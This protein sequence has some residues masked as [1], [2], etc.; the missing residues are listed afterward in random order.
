M[1]AGGSGARSLEET[2]TWAVALVCFVMLSIS[3]IIEHILHLI[4]KWLK[5]KHK[6]DLYE[7]LEKIKSELMLLGFISLLITVAYDSI[8]RICVSE[9]IAATWHPCKNRQ[10]P[11]S[12]PVQGN[13][14][15]GTVNHR[16]V[17]AAAGS[18]KCAPQGKV[19]LVSTDGIHQLHVFIFVWAVFHVLFCLLTLALGRLKMRR[20]KRWEEETKTPEYQS[21]HDPERFRF[22]RE[23]S[24]G[25]RH[26]SFW[27]QNPLLMWI[28]CFFR[29]F[30]RS[31][32]K[33]DYLALRH[34]FIMAHLAPQ[35]HERFD[36]RNY[37]VRSL[38]QDFK[39]VVG[40]SPPFWFFAVFF[41][42]SGTHGWYSYLWFPFIPLIIILVVGTKLQVIITKMAQG[43]QQRGEVV[44]GEPVVEPGDDLFWFKRPRFILY[45]INFALFQNAFQLAFFAWTVFQF[46]LRSCFNEKTQDV[47]IRITMGVFVQFLCSYV[48]LPL[49]ALVTQMGSTMRP[50]IFDE[51]VA[52][53]IRS[54]HQNAKK[55]V[56]QNKG[57]ASVTPLLG[58]PGSSPINLKHHHRNGGDPTSS[59]QNGSE[60]GYSPDRHDLEMAY[61]GH[62]KGTSS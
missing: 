8:S 37:I 56:R 58:T 61:L 7:S 50:T 38:E 12:H 44:K 36:F 27:T 6:N 21:S 40:I 13:G 57:S 55:Q 59:Q 47:V 52:T 28:V 15:S 22:A 16:R 62:N 43:T 48:T 3:V 49:Y 33:V 29:Q 11:M 31:V 25:R 4:G 41:F 30:V 42:L 53:A 24:F 54:W 19:P 17:L 26:L 18:D 10:E 34:G 9:R 1:A 32:P 46:G 2:P 39:F 20:W 45:L 35:S 23:T 60:A 51:R 5:K 14:T